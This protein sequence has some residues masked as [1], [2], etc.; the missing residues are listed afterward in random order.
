M[1]ITCATPA[2]RTPA[3]TSE[4]P[5]PA[6]RASSIR[7]ETSLAGIPARI[8]SP[9]TARK[10]YAGGKNKNRHWNK[11]TEGT[12]GA[13]ETAVIGAVERGG[14]VVAQVVGNVDTETAETFVDNTL[15]ADVTMVATDE[16]SVYRRVGQKRPHQIVNHGRG[17][18]VSG[19]AHTCT[20]DGYWSQLKRHAEY[21]EKLGPGIAYFFVD[22]P[23]DPED[24]AKLRNPGQCFLIC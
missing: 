23:G 24:K 11:R 5:A 4:A 15:A 18:Y 12:G 13:G 2:S 10:T 7:R 20:I 21:A 3:S 22:L 17:E 9:A 19:N 1:P 14:S 16:S 8:A 6:W